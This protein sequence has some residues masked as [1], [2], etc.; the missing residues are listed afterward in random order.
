[1]AMTMALHDTM[2]MAIVL[3]VYMAQ[4]MAIRTLVP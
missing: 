3:Q 4:T 2:A 1:M